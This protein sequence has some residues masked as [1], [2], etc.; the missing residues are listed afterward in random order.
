MPTNIDESLKYYVEKIKARKE[1]I[2]YVSI[3]IEFKNRQ[4]K[5]VRSQHNGCIWGRREERLEE[6]PHSLGDA[7]DAMCHTINSWNYTLIICT[8]FCIIS[9]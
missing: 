2:R 6:S 4:N 9:Y 8:Y 3:S 5:G 1:N 7:Y